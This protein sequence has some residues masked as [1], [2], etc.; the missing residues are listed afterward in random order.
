M[1]AYVCM[2]ACVFV[3]AYSCACVR[4]VV[5]A[6]ACVFLH[7]DICAMSCLKVETDRIKAAGGYLEIGRVCGNL[8]VSR[9]LGD[10]TYKDRPDLPAEAQ[11]I[12]AEADMTIIPR[13]VR[14]GRCPSH[15]MC[16]CFGARP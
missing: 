10:Y 14:A 1:C 6:C 8:A 12:S 4:V 5:S 7:T 2:H 16:A 13:S 9:S 3:R 11:K 15:G